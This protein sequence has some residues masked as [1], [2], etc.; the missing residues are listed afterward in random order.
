LSGTPCASDGN[1]CTT[2]ECNSTG[3]CIHALNNGPCDDG[4]FCNGEDLCSGNT[5]SLHL[6]N[7]CTNAGECQDTCDEAGDACQSPP[8][9]PCTDDHNVCTVDQCTA[10]G[11]GHDP[12]GS[13][14]AQRLTVTRVGGANNDRFA[15]KAVFP[16]ADLTT[17]PSDTGFQL[18]V[19]DANANV[20]YTATVP[21]SAIVDSGG[22]GKVFKY[23]DKTGAHPQ[24]NG[25]TSAQFKIDAKG[26]RVRVKMKM[27]NHDVPGVV[28]TP[29]VALSVLFGQN[30]ASD[31]CVTDTFAPCAP[32]GTKVICGD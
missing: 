25:L 28:S 14:I 5:C 19:L 12:R 30:T 2:D 26:G 31:D 32:R 6:G 27:A 23:S 7:P 15:I 4:I 21:A 29:R 17:R 18:D 11:C 1:Q 3:Q 9:T 8:G 16:R 10:G 13:F 24:A 22:L 20:I